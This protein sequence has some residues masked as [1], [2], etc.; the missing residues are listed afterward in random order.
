MTLHVEGCGGTAPT[1]L[2]AVPPLLELLAIAKAMASSLRLGSRA[3]ASATRPTVLLQQPSAR[4]GVTVVEVLVS[5]LL[6]LAVISLGWSALAHQRTV[7]FRLRSEMDLLSARRLAA[8]VIGK[9][10]RAGER[11]RDWSVSAPDSLALRA[12]RGWGPVCG[13]G[14]EPGSMVVAYH[15]ERAAN[16]V[17]D[18]VLI[19]TADGWRLADLTGRSSESRS[20]GM[21][22]GGGSEVWTIDPPVPGALVARIFERGSYHVSGGA[23]RYRRGLG[24]RQ[25]LTQ[26]VFDHDRSTMGVGVDRVM[27]RLV[28]DGIP[29]GADS[30]SAA[31]QFWAPETP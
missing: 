14:T 9:E 16:P 1:T 18:S 15:G 31:L 17:K 3:V 10:L 2:R 12:F 29:Q 11:G 6:G 7:A 26:D 8:I 28:A 20:C 27:L 22:L 21:D 23:L 25:P 13:F 30:N 24:G 5:L 4:R 19:L